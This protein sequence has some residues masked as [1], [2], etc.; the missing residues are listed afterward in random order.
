M[1]KTQI[2]NTKTNKFSF[3]KLKFGKPEFKLN[4]SKY[5]LTLLFIFA[6]INTILIA[7]MFYRNIYEFY[8]TNL[9][10][11]YLQLTTIIL[12]GMFFFERNYKRAAKARPSL[13]MRIIVILVLSLFSFNALGATSALEFITGRSF[14]VS[15]NNIYMIIQTV[16]IVGMIVAYDFPITVNFKEYYISSSKHFREHIGIFMLFAFLISF[17]G[18]LSST[19][20][21]G[22]AAI[23]VFISLYPAKAFLSNIRK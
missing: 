11:N 23:V 4:L 16:F 12:L 2:K 6:L 13:F 7:S 8:F 17:L 21:Y 22:L 1:H 15:T 18:L 10:K 3:P 19:F 5:D 9:E 20:I 14:F